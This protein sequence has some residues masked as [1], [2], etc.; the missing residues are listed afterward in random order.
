[1]KKDGKFITV[2]PDKTSGR[3]SY[4]NTKVGIKLREF[5]EVQYKFVESIDF[6]DNRKHLSYIA[7]MVQQGFLQPVL[8]PNSPYEFT[9]QG[10]KQI[11]SKLLTKH[12]RGKL[13]MNIGCINPMQ[14]RKNPDAIASGEKK[15]KK[16][17][18][19]RPETSYDTTPSV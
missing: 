10:L 17:V 19:I 1:L 14:Q 18:T 4:F 11:T 13:I 2:I 9:P 3:V 12:T 8:D 15:K 5:T 7:K 16:K 6:S